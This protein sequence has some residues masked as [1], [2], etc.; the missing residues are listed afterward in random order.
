MPITAAEFFD[1]FYSD[2]SNLTELFRLEG[3]K[4]TNLQVGRRVLTPTCRSPGSRS[5]TDLP[6]IV[7]TSLC[8]NV[9]PP[10]S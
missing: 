3:R 5:F 8:F 4:D 2:E 6:K 9:D 1:F 10:N 7:N